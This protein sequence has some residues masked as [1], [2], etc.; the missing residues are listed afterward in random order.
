M[1][2]D[3]FSACPCNS[4]GPLIKPRPRTLPTTRPPREGPRPPGLRVRSDGTHCPE[5]A[6]WPGDN[7]TLLIGVALSTAC[8]IDE[9]ITRGAAGGGY[10]A[11]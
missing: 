8:F 1:R 7:H 4:K 2:A 5:G 3:V 10:E 6:A 9:G 11:P